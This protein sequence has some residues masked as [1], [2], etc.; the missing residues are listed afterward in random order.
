MLSEQT[1]RFIETELGCAVTSAYNA[2]EAFKIGFFCEE[3]RGFHLHEDLCHVVLDGGE[4][5]LSNLVN[6]GTV[7]LNYR[8]GD[9]AELSPEA[10]PCGRTSPL[11]ST[12]QGRVNQVV[13][14]PD[15]E[16]LHPLLV[17]GVVKSF[18][19]VARY[20]LVQHEPDRFELKV[21]PTDPRAFAGTGDELL[22]RVRKLVRGCSV[23]LTLHD[24]L[25][26]GARG[27]FSPVLALAPTDRR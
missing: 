6:R 8:I 19:G 16:I 17:A 24:E 2:V 4:I 13:R 22:F 1:C 11:L 27:K 21:V 18:S 25:E 20:Q 15:G 5:V 7:L 12:L 23:E 9:L 26:P 10:C 3:R 14:L